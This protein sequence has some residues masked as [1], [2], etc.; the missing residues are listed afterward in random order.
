MKIIEIKKLKN[1]KYKIKF[2]EDEL[3]TYDNVILKYNLLYKKNIDISLY[4][5]MK[6]ENVYYDVYNKA[7]TFV[8]KKVRC[9]YEVQEFLNDFDLADEAKKEILQQLQKI[10]LI[11]D[12]KYIS[13]YIYDHVHLHQEGPYKIK[14]KLLELNLEEND[15]EYHLNRIDN[16]I[17]ENNIR[18]IIEKKIRTNSKLSWYK[19][20]QKIIFELLNKGYSNEFI[21]TIIDSYED[22]TSDY[23]IASNEF[24]KM[25]GKLSK[26]YS[27]IELENRVKQKMYSKGFDLTIINEL[28]DS[29]KN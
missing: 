5:K 25:Y 8:I 7:F 9:C 12:S 26:K 13:S 22:D 3:I 4:E 21:T 2:D 17:L 1:G 19:L 29:K 16:D 20:K 24:S 14:Q 23:T 10:G 27:G 15:I 6:Q 18:K 11:N 28:L